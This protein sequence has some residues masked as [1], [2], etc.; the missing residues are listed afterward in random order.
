MIV[1]FQTATTSIFAAGASIR[2]LLRIIILFKN[3]WPSAA[4]CGGPSI[5]ESAQSHSEMVYIRH[6]YRTYTVGIVGVRYGV[7]T[8]NGPP[9]T[10]LQ[11]RAPTL[12]YAVPTLFYTVI[13]Y[14][15]I[16]YAT[17][18]PAQ[19][20]HSCHLCLYLYFR[21]WSSSPDQLIL[22]TRGQRFHSHSLYCRI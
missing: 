14:T 8:G 18:R 7:Q 16:A 21:H 2:R 13:Q 22:T 12:A 15:K 10:P 1:H 4:V 20:V 3:L 5:R 6:R 9:C 11:G 17:L 19:N